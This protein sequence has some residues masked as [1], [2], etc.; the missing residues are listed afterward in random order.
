[1]IAFTRK[2]AE[3]IK[4][5]ILDIVVLV[6]RQKNILVFHTYGTYDIKLDR[7]VQTEAIEIAFMTC[8]SG[9]DGLLGEI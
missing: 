1:M 6:D 8:Q 5:C 7:K 3:V 9:S 2:A 4:Q